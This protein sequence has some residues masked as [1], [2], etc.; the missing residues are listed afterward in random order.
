VGRDIGYLQIFGLAIGLWKVMGPEVAAK[1]SLDLPRIRPEIKKRNDLDAVLR[2]L[3]VNGLF[4]NSNGQVAIEGQ[5]R[6]TNT[7]SDELGELGRRL[8]VESLKVQHD[9]RQ[10]HPNL[11]LLHIDR[12]EFVTHLATHLCE[13]PEGA[14]RLP[15]CRIL[16]LRLAVVT[17]LVDGKLKAELSV[18]DVGLKRTLAIETGARTQRGHAR[19]MHKQS[20]FRLLEALAVNY[21]PDFCKMLAC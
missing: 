18:L 8:R 12:A 20:L 19:T 13:S 1:A 4:A 5:I 7:A 16:T 15:L 17:R 10:I 6:T 3:Q 14:T 9:L 11:L 2:A 21:V